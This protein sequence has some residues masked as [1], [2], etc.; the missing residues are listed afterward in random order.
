MTSLSLGGQVTVRLLVVG[1]EDRLS[2]VWEKGVVSGVGVG[3][4]WEGQFYDTCMM[5][6]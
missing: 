3:S 5:L 4:Q 1:V 2:V 6:C